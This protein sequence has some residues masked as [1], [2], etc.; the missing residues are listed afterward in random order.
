MPVKGVCELSD[1]K[2]DFPIVA[3]MILEKNAFMSYLQMVQ[4]MSIRIVHMMYPVSNAVLKGTKKETEESL[5]MKFKDGYPDVSV[6]WRVPEG[7]I[8]ICVEKID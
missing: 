7:R 4:S 5:R 1:L 2:L 8:G 6:M 3:K